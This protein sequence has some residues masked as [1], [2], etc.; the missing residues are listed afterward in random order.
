MIAIAKGPKRKSASRRRNDK[1]LSILPEIRKQANFAFR[2]VTLDA[3]EELIQ[4]VI[5]QA[6]ALFVR[7]C[8]RGKPA[9][10]YPSP[11]AQFAIKK[12]R[13]GRR[14]GSRANIRDLTSPRARVAKG[15]TIERL[16][17][18]NRRN[19]EWRESLVED[20]TA[21]PAAIAMTRLDF[22]DWLSTLSTRDRELAQKLALGETTSAVACMF[23]VSAARISQLRRDLCKSWRTFVGELR[24][25]QVASVAVA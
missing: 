23:R 1:F 6:Y 21:G 2:R 22:A 19:G 15:V 17:R 10:V 24:D 4:E 13:A 8:H 18:F 3:R 14:I 7:L 12:V 11:L 5:A 20:R 16:D 25:D 9:L